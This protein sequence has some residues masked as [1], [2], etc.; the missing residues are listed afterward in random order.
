MIILG[1]M[2]SPRKLGNTHI[3][4]DEA[5]DGAREYGAETDLV[6]VAAMN[7][8]PCDGCFSCHKTK[9]CHIKDDMQK[10]YPKVLASA[11][12]IFATPVYFLGMTAQAK[13]VVD[14]LYVLYKT[15][16]LVNKVGGAIAVTTRIG[17]SQVWSFF[18]FFFSVSRM[19]PADFVAGFGR[20][21][22]DVRRDKH[23]MKAAREL[24][25]LVVSIAKKDFKLPEE[26]HETLSG[27]VS[28]KYGLDMSPSGDRFERQ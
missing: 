12:I 15:Q 2:C 26:Y 25:H 14:R 22:G 27:F 9:E 1:I 4:L 21:T 6:T 17:H 8:K 24:G 11:G 3:L 23:A 20:D 19:I 16:R 7:I 5:L 28:N 10:V 18:N 13:T